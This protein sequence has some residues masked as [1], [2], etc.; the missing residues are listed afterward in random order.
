MTGDVFL[1][2]VFHFFPRLTRWLNQIEDPGNKNKI[3][4]EP[5]HLL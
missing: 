3:T 1:K 2:T 4:Y 5:G